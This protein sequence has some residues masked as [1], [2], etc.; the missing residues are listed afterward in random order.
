MYKLADTPLSHL[1]LDSVVFYSV[2]LK[3]DRFKTFSELT[4]LRCYSMVDFFH[5]LFCRCTF[6]PK[7]I[8]SRFGYFTSETKTVV[9][10]IQICPKWKFYKKYKKRNYFQSVTFINNVWC[11]FS[12]LILISIRQRE[13]QLNIHLNMIVQVKMFKKNL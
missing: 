13:M 1:N 7:E 10:P 12:I 6:S 2:Y 5:M 9:C 8:D 3:Y 11:A 4:V